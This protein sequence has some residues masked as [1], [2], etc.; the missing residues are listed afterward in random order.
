[1]ELFGIGPLE[2]LFILII[3]L[4]VLGPRDM[5][6]AGNALG[7]FMRKTILSPTWLKIQREVRSLPYQMMREAGLEE[8]DLRVD[9]D[10]KETFKDMDL[11]DAFK[12]DV[13]SITSAPEQNPTP[14][15]AFHEQNTIGQRG[16]IPVDVPGEWLGLPSPDLALTDGH[17]PSDSLNPLSE[18]TS[19]PEI[20]ALPEETAPV[21]PDGEPDEAKDA[22]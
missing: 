6:K 5:V 13:H 16:D 22:T 7:R 10:L 4:I 15:P 21:V 14:L 18:W 1:M 11:R 9:M 19:A 2:L 12:K 3:A 8:A 20:E 17:G